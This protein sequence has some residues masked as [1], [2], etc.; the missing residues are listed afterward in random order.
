M[1]PAPN[2]WLQMVLVKRLLRID[3]LHAGRSRR[4]AQSTPTDCTTDPGE[5]TAG[6]ERDQR[7]SIWEDAVDPSSATDRITDTHSE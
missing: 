6:E 7:A 3:L 5:R 4:A 1:G 2:T